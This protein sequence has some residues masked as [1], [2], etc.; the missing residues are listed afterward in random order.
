[1]T[2]R[3]INSIIEDIDDDLIEK[4]DEMPIKQKRIS[5]VK[6]GS[7]AAAFL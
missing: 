2:N 3:E 6:L 7:A 1:M 5:W 4:A